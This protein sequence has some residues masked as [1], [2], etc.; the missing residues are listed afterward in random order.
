MMRTV[1]PIFSLLLSLAAPL[2]KSAES[3]EPLDIGSRRELFVDDYLID[4]LQE[5]H[6]I[7][8][9]P[10]PQ[11]VSLVRN[12]H[13]RGIPAATRRCFRTPG[14]TACTIAAAI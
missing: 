5:A 1:L 12:K 14:C 3:L 9:H 10:T 2:A 6:R 13:G 11:E 8:H 4:A 7:L